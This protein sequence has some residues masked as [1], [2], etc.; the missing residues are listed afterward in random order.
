[1]KAEYSQKMDTRN[2]GAGAEP[3]G[4]VLGVETDAASHLRTKAET[5]ELMEA[6]V[7]RG[8][9]MLAYERVIWSDSDSHKKALHFAGP[10][11]AID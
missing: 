9:L 11:D 5:E 10:L 6:V 8:N 1:M 7:S 3:Y 4:A 2:R